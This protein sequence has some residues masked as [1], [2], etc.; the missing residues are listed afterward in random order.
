MGQL[1]SDGTRAYV[2]VTDETNG[3]DVI[4]NLNLAVSDP[5]SQ[6]YVTSVGGTSFGHGSQRWDHRRRSR[7]GTTR[8]TTRR[9]RAEAASPSTFAMPAYQQAL[10]M[11]S[12]SSGTPAQIRAATAARFPT[13]P[14]TPT[15]APATSS[16]TTQRHTT[17]G[18]RWRDQR[19][20]AAVGRCPRGRCLRRRQHGRLRRAEPGSLSLG[21]AVSRHLP[22]RR[23]VGEQR[24]QRHRRRPVPRHDRVR[25]GDRSRHACGVGAGVG[26]DGHPAGRDGVGLADLRE[27]NP[28][29]HRIGRLRR[30]G[31][32]PVRRGD[33]H[34]W[35]APAPRSTARRP[36]A[37]PCRSAATRSLPLRAA[38]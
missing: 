31:D 23:H 1:V 21:A 38:G 2:W 7:P 25:H 12:G 22:Q 24:L 37:R 27:P 6:P 29:F 34:E 36:S 16:T 20:D 17:A 13:C 18:P 28:D 5:A 8:S 35:R 10:G 9:A 32:Y 15:R 3:G 33:Q 11:V 4:Q 14:P 19:G 26:V 30:C